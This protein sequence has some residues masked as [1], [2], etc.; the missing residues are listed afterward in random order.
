[1][2]CDSS[3]KNGFVEQVYV[4]AYFKVNGLLLVEQSNIMNYI[5]IGI[6]FSNLYL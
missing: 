3:F 6:L 5:Y 4:C 1:M 2:V